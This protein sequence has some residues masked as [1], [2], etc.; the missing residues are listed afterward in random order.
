MYYKY[1][2]QYKMAKVI[3]SPITGKKSEKKYSGGPQARTVA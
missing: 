3:D 2:Q 1:Y